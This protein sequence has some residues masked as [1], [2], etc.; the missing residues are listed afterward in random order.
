MTNI[1]FKDFIKIVDERGDESTYYGIGH[2]TASSTHH[3]KVCYPIS[4]LGLTC[5]LMLQQLHRD[6]ESV[7]HL[8]F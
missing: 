5:L 7:C 3:A 4:Y 6:S 8:P 1:R 2:F